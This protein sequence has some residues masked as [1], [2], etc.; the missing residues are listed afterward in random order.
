MYLVDYP[1]R[2]RL[3]AVQQMKERPTD[4][5]TLRGAG[6][7]RPGERSR[8]SIAASQAVEPFGRRRRA[9]CAN[10][11]VNLEKIPLRAS[12]D[13]DLV[14]HAFR[15][16]LSNTWRTGSVRPAATSLSPCR[17]ASYTSARA[18]I[19]SRHWYAAAS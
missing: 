4:F 2:M 8:L 7:L 19:S 18:A 15:R 6:G 1:I 13:L 9:Y 14:C 12:G 3:F 17:I 11:F 16:I 5:T 10:V